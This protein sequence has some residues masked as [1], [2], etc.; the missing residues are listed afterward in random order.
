MK[1]VFLLTVLLFVITAPLFAQ[2]AQQEAGQIAA[3]TS[4]SFPIPSPRVIIND[5][6]NDTWPAPPLPPPTAPGTAPMPPMPPLPRITMDIVTVQA[7]SNGLQ[8]KWSAT[9]IL[10]M[11]R[12]LALVPLYGMIRIACASSRASDTRPA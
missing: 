5:T 11:I 9:F 2:K 10:I 7:R 3:A 8:T 4:L 6:E 1:K 12:T